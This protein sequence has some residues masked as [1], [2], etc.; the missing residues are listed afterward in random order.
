MRPYTYQLKLRKIGLCSERNV[1]CEDSKISQY[2]RKKNH[3]NMTLIKKIT[4]L[5]KI[6]YMFRPLYARFIKSAY[7]YLTFRKFIT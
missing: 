1:C 5:F 2:L 4:I 6:S 3:K 7:S